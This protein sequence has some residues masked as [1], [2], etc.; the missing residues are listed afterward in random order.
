MKLN[1]FKQLA[2]GVVLFGGSVFA[3]EL[4]TAEQSGEKVTIC[5]ATH[6]KTNPYVEITPANDGVLFGH[7]DDDFGGTRGN[8]QD[9]EDI[10]PPF[11]YEGKMYSQNWTEIG[12][13]ILANGCELVISVPEKP[14]IEIHPPLTDRPDAPA[15]PAVP[16]PAT[17][18]FTG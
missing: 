15:A 9:G 18:A 8:H 2:S 7:L 4:A 1:K 3:S 16:I 6:S 5:H 12:R 13:A 11:E 14:V 17:P 10:I